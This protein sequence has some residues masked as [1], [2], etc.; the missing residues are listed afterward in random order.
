MNGCYTFLIHTL[1]F[2]LYLD[3]LLVAIWLGKTIT[4]PTIK[5]V[6]EVSHPDS[7]L[8]NHPWIFFNVLSK[9]IKN[10]IF[11]K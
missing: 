10:I 1:V 5:L 6:C 7:I 4:S 2:M 11:P 9:S 3:S 8:Q